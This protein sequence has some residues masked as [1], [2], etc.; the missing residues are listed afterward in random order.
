MKYQFY[1]NATTNKEKQFH[2]KIKLSLQNFTKVGFDL[3]DLRKK[4]YRIFD[5]IR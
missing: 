5:K 2:I 4:A 3:L 1:K